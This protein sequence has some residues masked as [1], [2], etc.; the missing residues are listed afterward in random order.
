M[1]F[2]IVLFILGFFA[3]LCGTV[4]KVQAGLEPHLLSILCLRL[5]LF[6]EMRRGFL[7]LLFVSHRGQK[8]NN[9]TVDCLIY[10]V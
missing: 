10:E 4:R 9:V 5:R 6:C 3:D 2:N 7:T 8:V 1:T